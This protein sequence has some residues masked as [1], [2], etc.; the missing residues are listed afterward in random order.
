MVANRTASR[1]SVKAATSRAGIAGIAETETTGAVTDSSE[2]ADGTGG[3]EDAGGAAEPRQVAVVVAAVEEE[4]LVRAV[5][6]WV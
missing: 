6:A 2:M 3:T 1:I 5:E 4:G